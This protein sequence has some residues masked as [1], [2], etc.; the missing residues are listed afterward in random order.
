[1]NNTPDA[2]SKGEQLGAK[3]AELN[4]LQAR[5]KPLAIV[6]VIVGLLTMVSAIAGSEI[7]L[8]RGLY[9]YTTPVL[10]VLVLVRL[11]AN[12]RM[13]ALTKEIKALK[14]RE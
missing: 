4:E 10:I 5:G 13:M 11:P 3:Q 7:G 6:I 14:Q 1:M 8:P 2:G 12:R 9:F